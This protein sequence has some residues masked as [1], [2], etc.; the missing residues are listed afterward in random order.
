MNIADKLLVIAENMQKVFEAGTKQGGGGVEYSSIIHNDDNTVTLTETNGTE[1]TMACEY[2]GDKLISV[3]Y[4]GETIELTYD[5]DVLVAI[6]GMSVDM[7]NAPADTRLKELVEGTMTELV[8]DT[9]TSVGTYAFYYSGIQSV[10]LPNCT[11]VGQKG[12]SECSKLVSANLPNCESVGIAGFA[13]SDALVSVN[14]QNCKDV[15]AQ[16]F[17]YCDKLTSANLPNCESVGQNAFSGC[18]ALASVDFPQCTTLGNE[19]LKSCAKLTSIALPNC[20]TVGESAFSGCTTL[21]RVD[22]GS[23]TKINKSAFYNCKALATLIIRTNQVSSVT[24]TS[25]LYNTPIAS[26]TGYIYVPDDLVENYKVASGWLNYA[27][28]FKGLSELGG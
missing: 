12:F 22:L 11:S 5:G 9:I 26:G 16:S 7:S 10:D 6:G 14:L 25:L 15:K 8:D 1:H 20:T 18:S 2:D 4:D 21:E 23:V 17:I 24:I 3:T 28:Q 19:A 13:S 27:D